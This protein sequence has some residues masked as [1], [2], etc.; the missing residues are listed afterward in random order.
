LEPIA[1]EETMLRR[2]VRTI[3]KGLSVLSGMAFLFAP[4]TKDVGW[5]IMG[6]SIAF[7]IPCFV[8]WQK[9]E[10]DDDDAASPE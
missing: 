3:A 6:C 10:E 9:L 8:L 5:L 2:V 1:V 7:G 4:V